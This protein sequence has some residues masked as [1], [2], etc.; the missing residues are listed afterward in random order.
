MRGFGGET[1]KKNVILDL[2]CL[3]HWLGINGDVK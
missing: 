3:I 2:V 1:G